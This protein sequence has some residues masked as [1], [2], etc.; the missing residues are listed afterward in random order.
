MCGICAGVKDKVNLGDVLLADPAWDFQSGKRVKDK[1]NNAF[2]ISPHQ[3]HVSSLVRSHVQQLRNDQALL[4]QIAVNF[5]SDAPGMTRL[6]V[7]PVASGSA[8]LADGEVINEIKLLH[9]DLVG[10]EM[11]GYGLYAA[12]HAASEPKPLAFSLKGVCD[13]ADPDKANHAQRYAAYASAQVLRLLME[14]F[15]P[16]LL[17][18]N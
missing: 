3:L 11:E 17:D 9:R 10:V 4:S 6:V 2:S 1:K 12:A 15:G 5:G 14:R 18:R 8:V 7:G 16:R 13:F